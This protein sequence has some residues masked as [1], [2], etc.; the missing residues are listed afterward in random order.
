M[1]VP[2]NQ[3]VGGLRWG[4]FLEP[5]VRLRRANK[6]I[7]PEF[8]TNQES[9]HCFLF[10]LKVALRRKGETSRI[11]LFMKRPMSINVQAVGQ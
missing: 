3:A 7:A 6:P 10:L 8:P 11:G 5:S 2:I 1:R 4:M 9:A